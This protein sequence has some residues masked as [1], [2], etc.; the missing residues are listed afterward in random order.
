MARET[1][2]SGDPF[3][4]RFPRTSRAIRWGGFLVVFG[5]AMFVC[6]SLISFAWIVG[7]LSQISPGYEMFAEAYAAKRFRN[8]AL[9]LSAPLGAFLVSAGSFGV[10][11][12]LVMRPNAR[13]RMAK[14][15]VFIALAS[16]VC[17]AALTVYEFMPR[18]FERLSSEFIIS[19]SAY[20][21]TFLGWTFGVALVGFSALG[22]RSL[23]WWKLAPV[24]LAVLCV[25]VRTVVLLGLYPEG[26]LILA[27]S[28][29]AFAALL[30]APRALGGAGWIFFGLAL[31][32]A[33]RRELETAREEN[34]TAVRS[35]YEKAWSEGNSGLV[36]ELL[37]PGFVD[38]HHNLEG[39]D[40]FKRYL[41]DLR[42][43]FPDLSLDIRRQTVAE[44]V[45]TTRCAIRGT[46]RG[47]VLYHPPTNKRVVFSATFTDTMQDG[48]ITV[49]R[50]EVD[51]SSLFEQLGLEKS[52]E[53][54]T[55]R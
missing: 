2:Q 42:A 25:P 36:D 43:T 22:A 40:A 32:R 5:G 10:C 12:V 51:E 38:L 3:G 9:A 1:S 19:Q 35:F 55:A 54:R 23:G 29:P 33:W 53:P 37:A 7:W 8:M 18:Y 47:G 34:L 16:S 6:A 44:D 45:V 21:A 24:P 49:H 11:A 39:P 14:A 13:T 30:E 15:G 31:S 46:D 52:G 48:R 26:F 50:G 27:G 41:A 17:A 28:D 4:T 20:A